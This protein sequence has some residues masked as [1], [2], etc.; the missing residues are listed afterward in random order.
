MRSPWFPLMRTYRLRSSWLYDVCRIAGTR[1]FRTLLDVGANVGQTA[2][3]M[4]GYFPGADIH[5]FE[6]VNDTFVALRRRARRWPRVQAHRLALGRERG[7]REIEIQDDPEMNSL[8]FSPGEGAATRRL[9]RVEVAT[10]DDFCAEHGI[11]DVDVLKTDAQGCDGDVLAGA[12]GLLEG[13]RIA[14]VYAEVSFQPD[15]RV[16]T[17]FAG[18]DAFLV[19]RRFRLFGFYEQFGGARGGC[20][21][22]QFC[23]ALYFHPDAVRRRFRP[24]ASEGLPRAPAGAPQGRPVVPAC[25][26]GERRSP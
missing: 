4:A 19:S 12:A 15:D 20:G 25:A 21:F 26:S 1:D 17:P 3:A 16:N 7:S 24:G 9:E 2:G 23:N 13:E 11:G 22:L 8:R 14:F 10:L 5:S 18:L 6:P